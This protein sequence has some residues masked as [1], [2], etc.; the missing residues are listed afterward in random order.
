MLEIHK[1]FQLKAS[2]DFRNF[3]NCRLQRKQSIWLQLEKL[4]LKC[5]PSI[6]RSSKHTIKLPKFHAQIW[7]FCFSQCLNWDS[8]RI[9]LRKELNHHY[10][11]FLNEHINCTLL[12]WLSK[13]PENPGH[14]H[15]GI[16]WTNIQYCMRNQSLHSHFHSEYSIKLIYSYMAL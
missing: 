7:Q 3:K 8:T 1:C 15:A 5:N 12:F 13:W 11:E 10:P 9:L 6:N 4:W 14:H 16:F 2:I